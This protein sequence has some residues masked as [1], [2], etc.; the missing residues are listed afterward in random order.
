MRNLETWNYYGDSRVINSMAETINSISMEFLFE[1]LEE[2]GCGEPI[3][4]ENLPQGSDF[5]RWRGNN[6]EIEGNDAA[7]YKYEKAVFLCYLKEKF[8]KDFE[9]VP[10]FKD[11]CE[12]I[13]REEFS[14]PKIKFPTKWEICPQCQGHGSHV[15]PAIDCNGIT[16]SEWAEWDYEDQERYM[17]GGYDITCTQCKGEGKI[18]LSVYDKSPF[19]RWAMEILNDYN[20]RQR[21]FALEHANELRWG[22]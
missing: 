4:L 18:L 15:D 9:G 11:L 13:D 21:E 5:D 17:S 16:G 8:P 3:Y 1:Q 2:A 12:A 6:W 22:C 19:G 20:D 7:F 14:F 10:S